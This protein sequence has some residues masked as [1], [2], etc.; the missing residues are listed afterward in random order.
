MMPLAEIMQA[1]AVAAPAHAAV[2]AAPAQ[3][4]A[5]S[6]AQPPAQLP[7]LGKKDGYFERLG[8]E[9]GRWGIVNN[10]TSGKSGSGKRYRREIP[11]CFPGADKHEFLEA[12]KLSEKL[13][14]TDDETLIHPRLREHIPPHACF[15]S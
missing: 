4:A 1:A 10:D 12:R 3:A 6:S 9:C 11:R 7:Q 2:V 8:N 14:H 5:Q 15:T 13:R